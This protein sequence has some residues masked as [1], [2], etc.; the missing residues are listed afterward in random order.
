MTPLFSQGRQGKSTIKGLLNEKEKIITKPPRQHDALCSILNMINN[1]LS[2]PSGVKK[3][4][5]DYSRNTPGKL[6]RLFI[7]AIL[8]LLAY[9]LAYGK[10]IYH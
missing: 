4:R 5:Q 3:K 2:G 8:Q 9:R 1:G 10:R 7:H 6:P